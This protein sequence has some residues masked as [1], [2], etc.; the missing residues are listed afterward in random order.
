MVRIEFK[1][2]IIDRISSSSGVFSGDNLQVNWKACIKNNLG[3]GKLSGEGNKCI[4]NSSKVI[5]NEVRPE[6]DNRTKGR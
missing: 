5:K 1:D 3:Y 6:E 2:L 4:N